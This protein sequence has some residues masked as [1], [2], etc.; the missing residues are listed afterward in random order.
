MDEHLFNEGR[1]FKEYARSSDIGK[2]YESTSISVEDQEFFSS[3]RMKVLCISEKWCKDCGREVP[4]LA[5]IADKA[6][7]DLRIFGMDEIPALM[8]RYTTDGKKKIPVFVFFDEAFREVG[9]FIEKPPE[10]KTALEVLKEILGN[11]I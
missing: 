3:Y 9:R 10:G 2:M 4:F 6:G 8:E 11:S 1:S 5:Y 7:W